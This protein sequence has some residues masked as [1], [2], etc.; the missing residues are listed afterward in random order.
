MSKELSPKYNPA[1]VEAG[2]YLGESSLDIIFSP[3]M[4]ISFI[5][6]IY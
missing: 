5:S 2:L 1:E 4:N 3:F 6:T